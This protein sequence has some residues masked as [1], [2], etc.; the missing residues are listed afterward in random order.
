MADG[1]EQIA[2]R[3]RHTFPGWDDEMWRRIV[4]GPATQLAEQLERTE[5]P[6]DETHP[7]LEAYLELAAEAVGLGYLYPAEATGRRNFFHLAWFELVPADLASY[8]PDRQLELLSACWNVGENLETRPSW[9]QELFLAE[10]EPVEALGDLET[11]VDEISRKIVAAPPGR[12]E[13]A[14]DAADATH[15]EFIDLGAEYP[16]FLPGAVEFLAPGVACVHHRHEDLDGTPKASIGISLVG[17][18]EVLGTMRADAPETDGETD[19]P[20]WWEAIAARDPGITGR[21]ATDS[22]AWRAIASLDTSQYVVAVR[23]ARPESRDRGTGA[24]G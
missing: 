11:T 18:P 3:A 8:S 24:S 10:F 17:A 6:A 22:N 7:V 19:V 14:P 1:S 9:L 4:E 16:R 13:Y 20:E 2:E 12:L 5:R 21:F 15:V 23:P